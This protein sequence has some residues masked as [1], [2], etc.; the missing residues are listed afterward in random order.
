MYNKIA[1]TMNE[2][3]GCSDMDANLVQNYL[4]K[5]DK[6]LI[7]EQEVLIME[8]LMKRYVN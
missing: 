6:S 1:R 3:F 5:G 2:K 4:V 8:I 7:S